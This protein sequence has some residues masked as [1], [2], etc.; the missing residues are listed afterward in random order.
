MTSGSWLAAISCRPHVA[1]QLARSG[2]RSPSTQL[3][4]RLLEALPAGEVVEI[5]DNAKR[6]LQ[7][8]CARS[9][10]QPRALDLQAR[11]DVVPPTVANHR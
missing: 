4:D 6:A 2:G 1:G 7:R 5:D 9:T 11:G 8:R 3:V 10:R